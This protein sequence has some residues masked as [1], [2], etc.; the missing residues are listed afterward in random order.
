MDIKYII[1][2]AVCSIVIFGAYSTGYEKAET[3]ATLKIESM[4]LDHA[5][6]IIKAQNKEKE[7]YEQ[8]E[9]DLVARYDAD[10]KHY[11]DRMRQL[12]RKLN[13]K[14]DVEAVRSERDRCFGLAVRG[15]R[16]LRRA[17]AIIES[18]E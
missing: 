18:L 13:A 4:K 6:Q 14:G 11:V 15:E 8:K 2:S 3:E 12:E 9:K 10:R 1:A 7:R 17:D 16:L 5:N